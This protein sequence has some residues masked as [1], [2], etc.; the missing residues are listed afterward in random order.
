MNKSDK[1]IKMSKDNNPN[2]M[3]MLSIL[4]LSIAL[5]TISISEIVPQFK[6]QLKDPIYWN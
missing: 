5:F 6:L 3:V 1:K 2:S 4:L